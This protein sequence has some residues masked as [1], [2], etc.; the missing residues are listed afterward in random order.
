VFINLTQDGYVLQDVQ[1]GNF[2]FQHENSGVWGE[3]V[4]VEWYFYWKNHKL[5]DTPLETLLKH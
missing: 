1:T 5:F 3:I 4:S 2:W